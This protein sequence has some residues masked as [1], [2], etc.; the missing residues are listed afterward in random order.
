[1]QGNNILRT[2][3]EFSN[4]I[5]NKDKMI[6]TKPTSGKYL[7]TINGEDFFLISSIAIKVPINNSQALAGNK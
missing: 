6:I 2:K 3:Y 1:M 5:K 7:P 4:L